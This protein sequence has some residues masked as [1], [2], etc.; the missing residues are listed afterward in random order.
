MSNI[1]LVAKAAGVS[2]MTVSRYFNDPDK[3]RPST[4]AR[5]EAAVEALQYVPNAAARSLIHGRTETLALIVADITNPFFTTLARGVEDGAQ[6]HGYTLIL[7]NADETLAKE[8]AYLD[9]MV[10]RRVDG[11]ILSPAPGAAHNLHVLTRR[12]MPV[13]LIDRRIADEDVDV[14]R[15]D[16]TEAGHILTRHLIELGHRR[17]A[18]VGGPAGVSS[19]EDRLAGYRGALAEADLPPSAFLGRYDRTSGDEIVTRLTAD[20]SGL[21]YTALIAA[22]NTVAGGA[23]AALARAGL[24]VPGDVSLVC[25]EEYESDAV[26]DPFLTVVVQPAYE[27]GRQATHL[28][29]DRI[30]GA[31]KAARDV[32]LPVTL[33]VRRS[34]APPA[35]P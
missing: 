9:V 29:F 16:S 22:N 19:L 25:F 1:V 34:A 30:R 28:L 7:G 24:R 12:H 26:V 2:T 15:G 13:V 10:A 21:A 33:R 3:L 11:V 20:G 27:M 14:V 17:I 23:L 18:F 6:E 5:V 32:V 31:A 8:R 4:R 35:S